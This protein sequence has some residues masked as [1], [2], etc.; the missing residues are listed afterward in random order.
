MNDNPQLQNLMDSA[1]W[2][3][4]T[5]L[6]VV[7]LVIGLGYL[8]Y[9]LGVANSWLRGSLQVIAATA[10]SLIAGHQIG[11]RGLKG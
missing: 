2:L 7:L 1:T 9:L 10:V 11:S 8:L 4:V 3:I 5:A 6:V